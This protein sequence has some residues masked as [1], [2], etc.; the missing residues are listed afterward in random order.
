MLSLYFILTLEAIGMLQKPSFA[1]LVASS[2][3]IL[4]V[5]NELFSRGVLQS[6]TV[7]LVGMWISTDYAALSL[8]L[9]GYLILYVQLSR[10]HVQL[11][12]TH[13]ELEEAHEGLSA[14][15]SQIETLTR[16][17]ERQ[18]LARD[19]HDTLSQGL[20]G[21]KLQLEA[22]DALLVQRCHDQAQEV[23]R[24]AMGRVQET[25]SE[26]RG[27]IDALRSEGTTHNCAESARALIQRF[28]AA[29]GIAC[30]VDVDALAQLPPALHEPTLRVIGE[31]LTNI[32]RHAQ[33]RQVWIRAVLAGD[34]LSIDVRDDGVGFDPARD[35]VQPGHYGLLGLRERAR[36]LGGSLEILSAPGSGTSLRVSF[37]YNPEHERAGGQFPVQ[38]K[39]QAGE[40]QQESAHE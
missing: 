3:L 23:V 2:S 26:A 30:Q 10:A 4:F 19:L 16:L 9:V 17:T 40:R 8:F 5:F 6:W 7:A 13:T 34:L 12:V 25:L 29:T 38:E 22:V 32:A 39:R 28:T 18:R 15:A 36:L 1:I 37:P 31:G 27:A 21:L 11:E 14:A 33:A 24:Q 20:V 35:P